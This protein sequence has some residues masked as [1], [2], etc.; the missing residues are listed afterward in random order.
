MQT[1]S[2]VFERKCAA[3][4]TAGQRGIAYN[5]SPTYMCCTHVYGP[6]LPLMNQYRWEQHPMPAALN[7][8]GVSPQ[9]SA[10][11]RAHNLCNLAT[12]H[13]L[14]GTTPTHAP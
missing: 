11:S 3:F 10:L 1:F 8:I 6:S 7:A 13:N 2:D 5:L 9:G 12:A 14:S 4:S